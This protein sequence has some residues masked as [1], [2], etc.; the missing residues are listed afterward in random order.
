MESSTIQSAHQV[1]MASTSENKSHPHQ[2]IFVKDDLDGI[3]SPHNDSLVFSA[4]LLG[5]REHQILAD[6]G[7]RANTLV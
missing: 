1:I 2:I 5:M 3:M 7:A 4:H 6:T